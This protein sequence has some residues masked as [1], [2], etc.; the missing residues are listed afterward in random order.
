MF[1]RKR[2]EKDHLLQLSEAGTHCCGI[3]EN[4]KQAIFLKEPLQEEGSQSN[5]EFGE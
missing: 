2:G 1:P 4:Q 3:H 5:M